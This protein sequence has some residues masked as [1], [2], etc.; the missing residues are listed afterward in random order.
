V[1]EAFRIYG[2]L[3]GA[4]I[5]SDFQYRVSFVLFFFSQ[6]FITVLDF[7]AIAIIFEQVPQLAGWSLAEVAVLY[8]LTGTAFSIADMLVSAVENVS[9][10]IKDGTFDLLL[11]RPLGPLLQLVTDDFAPRRAGKL[12]QSVLI[13]GLALD[14]AHIHWTAGRVAMVPIT[15][16]SGT[17][18][19]GAVWVL[20]SCVTFWLVEGRE[21]MNAFTYGG[22][23]MTQYPLA[24]YGTWLRRLLAY[25]VPMAFVNYFPAVYLLGRHDLLG[26]PTVVRF[27]SPAIAVVL[28]VIAHAAWTGAIRHYRSTG[29]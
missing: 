11:I 25:L 7:V 2:R 12:L 19:F 5:R 14:A 20:T 4:R 13:L 24:V 3:V 27:A 21:V 16:L 10:R 22:N 18:I 15:V 9:V 17:V 23:Y 1:A 28:A 29:S 6:G 26:A 8:G